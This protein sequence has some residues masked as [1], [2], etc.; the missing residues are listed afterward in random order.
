[1]H[2]QFP[3]LSVLAGRMVQDEHT[4]A[5]AADDYGHIVHARPWAVLQPHSSSDVAQVIDFARRHHLK[6]AP[7]GEGH[8]THGQPQ[9]TDGIVVDMTQLAQVHTIS[10]MEAYVDAGISWRALLQQTLA[11]GLTPP[12]FTD[13]I[14][15]TVGGTLSVGGVGAQTFRAG[16]QADNVGELEV[17]TG[18]GALV[19]CSPHSNADLFDMCRAG[20]GQFGIIVRARIP[21]VAA[22]ARV[23]LHRTLHQDLDTF[24][25][26]LVALTNDPRC[27][28]LEGFV[29]PNDRAA[30]L[31]L[32]GP[33]IAACELP[34]DAGMWLFMTEA[35][36]YDTG[37]P[38]RADAAI[39]RHL[40]WLPQGHVVQE[41]T[42]Y[43]FIARLD[44]L[45]ASLKQLGAWG[46]PHPWINLIVGA[47]HAA[48][49]IR[50]ALAILT[51]DDVAGAVLVYPY[52]RDRFRAPLF[53]VPESRHMFKFALLRNTI[54]PLPERV[55]QQ[56]AVNRRLYERCRQ[57]GGSRYPIDSVPMEKGDWPRHF[58]AAWPQMQAAKQKF[59]PDGLLTPGQHIFP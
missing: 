40:S 10:S 58:G 29:V 15:V 32:V 36:I 7:R 27:D 45:L 30:L 16:T 49:F 42:Y 31:Q 34:P 47:E 59:D 46:V 12:V 14:D 44:P 37:E 38:E 52:R 26:G 55:Q 24:L 22:P 35:T 17:V 20:L 33:E 25:A 3:E 28:G 57:L 13:Y 48:T 11:H 19:T 51:P 54:P 39:L 56:I 1:M 8:S 5:G 9:V 2:S 6:L 41:L 50:E 21:L 23:R 53:R 43:E 18:T 4:L